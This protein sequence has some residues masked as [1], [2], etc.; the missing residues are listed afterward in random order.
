[1]AINVTSRGKDALHS[2][3]D[4]SVQA[5][6]ATKG[7]VIVLEGSSLSVIGIYGDGIQADTFFNIS[8]GTF[9]ISTLL[10]WVKATSNEGFFKLSNGV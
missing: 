2:E 3:S 6:D 7:Y 4:D 9:N 10:T 5:F 8:G 1:M